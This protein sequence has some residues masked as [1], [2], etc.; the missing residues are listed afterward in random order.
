MS[1][2]NIVIDALPET[3]DDVV[4]DIIP[5]PSAE[6]KRKDFEILETSYTNLTNNN[7]VKT[8]NREELN[9]MAKEFKEKLEKFKRSYTIGDLQQ[10]IN[11]FDKSVVDGQI[12]S[13]ELFN[14]PT[15]FTDAINILRYDDLSKL[16][17]VSLI[18]KVGASDS[19][20]FKA[21]YDTKPC[22][23][24][25]FFPPNPNLDYEQKIYRYIASRNDKIKSLYEDYFVKIYNV[26]KVMSVDF[27]DFLNRNRVENITNRM[28]WSVSNPA[29]NKKLNSN[30]Y[31]YLIITE[32]ME[33][34]T[35]LDFY[36]RNYND[37]KLITNTLF[38]MIYGIY[39]MNDKLKLMHNDNH[40]GN[41]L[42]KIG[43][44]NVDTLYQIGKTEYVKQ[45]NY[46]LC[47]F[48]FDL[49]FLENIT[50]THLEKDTKFWLVQNKMSAKDIWTILNSL[51]R[52]NSRS[53][54]APIYMN[55]IIDTILNG[56]VLH[57]EMIMKIYEETARGKFWNAYCVD[58]VQE[59]CIIP[60]EPFLYPLNVLERFIGNDRIKSML[61][62][63]DQDIYYRKY[64]KYKNKYLA[65]KKTNSYF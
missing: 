5:E 6:E 7:F 44:P 19:F 39:L 2:D 56:S 55:N 10:S 15:Q 59:P 45:K 62:F 3:T 49:A 20:M 9:V 35:Y 38:D 37:E 32:D 46:R 29:L 31:V 48:D 58:N 53:G 57:K 42:I 18:T 27:T 4:I 36:R 50:N 63:I 41:V 16:T 51:I 13:L 60:D 28:F 30:V 61:D 22:Y 24:K 1:S 47:F 17:G 52:N 25:A 40:F 23:I 54:I 11:I 64:I 8:H 33:G 12:N 65:L 26:C 21:K 34:E 43:L 14:E